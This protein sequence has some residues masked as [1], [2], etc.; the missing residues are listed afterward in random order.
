MITYENKDSHP[1]PTAG[2]PYSSKIFSQYINLE[3]QLNVTVLMN[4]FVTCKVEMNIYEYGAMGTYTGLVCECV[5][6]KG[7]I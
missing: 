4:F 1:G 7:Q 3:L 6:I 2:L 5:C